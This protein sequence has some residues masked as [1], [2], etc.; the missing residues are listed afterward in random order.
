M[1]EL[2]NK[3]TELREKVAQGEWELQTTDNYLTWTVWEKE[4]VVFWD[5]GFKS[6]IIAEYI[7]ALHN[8]LDE[9]IVNDESVMKF[10]KAVKDAGCSI[11]QASESCMNCKAIKDYEEANNAE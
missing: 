5:E 8:A 2:F 1:R 9:L 4:K 11:G 7:V 6:V 10:V 3:L